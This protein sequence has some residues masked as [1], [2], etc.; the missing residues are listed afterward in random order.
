MMDIPGGLARLAGIV[1]DSNANITSV[2]YDRA[3]AEIHIN[4]VILHITC[5]VSGKEHGN[6]LVRNIEEAGYRLML[7]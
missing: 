7:S 3:S 6:R 5:E 1:A 4:E 2:R